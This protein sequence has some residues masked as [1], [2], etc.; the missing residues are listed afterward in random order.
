MAQ[1]HLHEAGIHDSMDAVV[2][3]MYNEGDGCNTRMT[4]IS[5]TT[6]DDRADREHYVV[7]L[8]RCEGGLMVMANPPSSEKLTFLIAW[9]PLSM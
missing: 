1:R 3:G 5:K 4:A 9:M 7:I 6:D 2:G 8:V